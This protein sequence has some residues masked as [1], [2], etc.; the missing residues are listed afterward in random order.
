MKLSP[1]HFVS[2]TGFFLILDSIFY[3]SIALKHILEH[4]FDNIHNVYRRFIINYIYEE[5]IYMA[6]VTSCTKL[7]CF[8]D[9]LWERMDV[10][11]TNE[12]LSFSL[13]TKY[14]QFVTTC[15]H[16]NKSYTNVSIKFLQ[17]TWKWDF[18]HAS[19]SGSRPLRL[20][21]KLPKLTKYAAFPTQNNLLSNKNCTLNFSL[22][23]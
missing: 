21:Q 3:Q 1:E 23:N 11:S 8:L 17:N 10:L 2:I 12:E 14:A 5:M 6:H 4:S 19:V 18:L 13:I 9:E 22:D 20:R 15:R 7:C 16:Y